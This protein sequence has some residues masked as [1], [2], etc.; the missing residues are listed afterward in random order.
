MISCRWVCMCILGRI[1]QC[2]P[3]MQH[4]NDAYIR[5]GNALTPSTTRL[6][7]HSIF[8]GATAEGPSKTL[9]NLPRHCKAC[10]IVDRL[11]KVHT[12][13]QAT[14]AQDCRRT[15]L[16]QTDRQRTS[17][18]QSSRTCGRCGQLPPPH[19]PMHV[20]KRWHQRGT[21]RAGMS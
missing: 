5:K 8:F 17:A 6:L 19:V 11:C 15:A 14:N 10:F 16:V 20:Q 21:R 9:I 4:N 13:T 18:Q 3:F 2:Q 1:R 12:C 7:P